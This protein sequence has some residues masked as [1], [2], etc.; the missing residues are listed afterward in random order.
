[1]TDGQTIVGDWTQ[2]LPNGKITETFPDGQ[3]FEGDYVEGMRHGM[4]KLV[5][6]DG[7]QYEGLFSNNAPGPRG[8]LTVGDKTYEGEVSFDEGKFTIVG[9]SANVLGHQEGTFEIDLAAGPE[10]ADQPADGLNLQLQ[11]A[12]Q[13]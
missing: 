6:P 5:L 3:V 4:G 1:M 11:P 7:I 13:P 10:G 2:D 9:R 12:D 8:K